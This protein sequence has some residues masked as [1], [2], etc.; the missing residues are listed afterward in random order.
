M[1]NIDV[2]NHRL[3]VSVQQMYSEQMVMR[4]QIITLNETV[5]SLKKHIGDLERELSDKVGVTDI[6]Q[7]VKQSEIIKKINESESVGMDSTVRISLDGLVT[8]ESIVEHTTDAI[9]ISAND[10]KGVRDK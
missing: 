7:V 5:N 2:I 6:K 9:K 1:E 10:I 4:G 8:A 3:E